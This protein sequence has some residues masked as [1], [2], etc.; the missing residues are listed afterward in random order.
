MRLHQSYPPSTITNL[1]PRQAYS[2]P[3]TLNFLGLFVALPEK[4][5]IL[6]VGRGSDDRDPTLADPGCIRQDKKTLCWTRCRPA[7]L[8]RSRTPLRKE[9]RGHTAWPPPV[10]EPMTTELELFIAADSRAVRWSAPCI[11]QITPHLSKT[12]PHFTFWYTL[13]Q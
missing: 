5:K 4:N 10:L 1:P 13:T 7:L 9:K 3:S 8:P 12:S 11:N 2:A 6:K